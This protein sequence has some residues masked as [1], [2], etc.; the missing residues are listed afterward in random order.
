MLDDIFTYLHA[1]S[2]QRLGTNFGHTFHM[3][4]SSVIIFNRWSPHTICHTYL[5]VDFSPACWKPSVPGDIFYLLASL[6][7]LLVPLKNTCAT[8][9][10]L[11]T[12]Y[13]ASFHGIVTDS[14]PAGLK[15]LVYLLLGVH[16]LFL[17]AHSW[18]TRKR[19]GL[20]MW[21]KMQWL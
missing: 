6:F 10:Y 2:L 1:S 3:S 21:K 15:T 14:S 13:E 20:N 4:K 5:D 11:Q 7:E 12:L 16:S 17:S 19:R 9:C 18:T 8:R